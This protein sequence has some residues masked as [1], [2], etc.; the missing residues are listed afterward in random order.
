MGTMNVNKKFLWKQN[1]SVQMTSSLTWG[2]PSNG[3]FNFQADEPKFPHQI[4]KTAP[5]TSTKVSIHK[6]EYPLFVTSIRCIIDV[7]NSNYT[8][9]LWCYTRDKFSFMLLQAFEATLPVQKG[10]VTPFPLH[11]TAEWTWPLV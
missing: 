10:V 4:R 8:T 6:Q 3:I 2:T 5:N 7:T 11:Y 9:V 1:I